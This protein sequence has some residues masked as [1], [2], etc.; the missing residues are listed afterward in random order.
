[1]DKRIQIREV[2]R[3][4]GLVPLYFHPSEWVSADLLKALYDAGCRVVEYT[5]RGNEALKKFGKLRLL[6]DQKLSGMYLGAGTIKDASAASAFIDAGADFLISPG[7]PEDVFDIA[8]SEKILW[9]PGCMTPTEIMKAEAFGISFVKLFPGN[10]L[11]PSFVQSVKEIFPDISFIPTG[12][13][14]PERENIRTWFAAGV[15]A[16][17][18]GSKLI[19][20]EMVGEK[21]YVKLTLLAKEVLSTID[22]IRK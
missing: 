6:C 3:A 12:G 10:L 13:L 7:L 1:M 4:Q 19:K 2:I 18:M 15:S 11:G 5:N 21:E 14:E 16:V 17:G 8:Y 9:I 22:D 20:K